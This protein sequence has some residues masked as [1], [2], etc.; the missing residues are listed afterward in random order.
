[1]TQIE[2]HAYYQRYLRRGKPI[3]YVGTNFNSSTR[4]VDDW[5]HEAVEDNNL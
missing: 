1:M 2:T 3:T 5:K 4:T